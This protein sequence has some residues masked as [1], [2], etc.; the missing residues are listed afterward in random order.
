MKE[1]QPHEMPSNVIVHAK[2]KTL[3]ISWGDFRLTIPMATLRQCCPCSRC[4]KQRIDGRPVTTSETPPE[5]TAIDVVGQYALNVKFSDGHDR[6]IY[7]WAYLRSLEAAAAARY[8]GHD[9]SQC[10]I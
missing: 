10:G 4:E 5:V 2:S 3:E 7:P 8:V 6:G 1:E 9:V